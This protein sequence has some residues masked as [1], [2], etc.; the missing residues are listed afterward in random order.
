MALLTWRLNS[1]GDRFSFYIINTKKFTLKVTKEG[2]YTC[3][4]SKNNSDAGIPTLIFSGSKL[5]PQEA[6]IEAEKLF[7]E[8]NNLPEIPLKCKMP[9]IQVKNNLIYIIYDVKDIAKYTINGNDVRKNSK[10]Y[11]GPFP[12]EED[13]EIIKVKSFN[14]DKEDSEQF[15]LTIIRN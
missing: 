4:S 10:I 2:Q 5:T 12:L 1:T 9:E 14:K 7:K 3:H 8:Y 6:M 13:I 15:T 11:K